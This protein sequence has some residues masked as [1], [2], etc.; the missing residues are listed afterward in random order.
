MERLAAGSV[1]WLRRAAVSSSPE[2]DHV[3]WVPCAGYKLLSFL[4]LLCGQRVHGPVRQL[5]LTFSILI[6][7]LPR[8]RCG[9]VR[10]RARRPGADRSR[11][12]R[13]LTS[14]VTGGSRERRRTRVLV[15]VSGV[16][17][18]ADGEAGAQIGRTP[19][20]RGKCAWGQT[21]GEPGSGPA[22]SGCRGPQKRAS[23]RP[24]VNPVWGS[25]D[26][27]ESVGAEDTSAFTLV[28]SLALLIQFSA[29][30]LQCLWKY[31]F[32]REIHVQLR[33]F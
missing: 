7:W 19:V 22:E 14:G 11:V 3:W 32:V 2:P 17:W 20:G 9:Q 31:N 6:L 16:R 12:H 27:P 23:H 29:S 15:M 18:R 25:Q 30:F 33:M 28:T 13:R 26:G 10:A 1:A 5:T 21:A 24:V 8:D 4:W